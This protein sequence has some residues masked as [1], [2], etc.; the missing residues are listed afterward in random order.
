M[1]TPP[2]CDII[3]T[4]QQNFGIQS[5]EFLNEYKCLFNISVA[6]LILK[7]TKIFYFN[8]LIY[9]EGYPEQGRPFQEDV[10]I[11]SS[12]NKVDIC[13][14]DWND[15]LWVSHI[16]LHKLFG[17]NSDRKRKIKIYFYFLRYLKH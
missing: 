10:I 1:S 14:K 16:N 17:A 5:V 12:V 4:F 8:Y 11:E 9:I 15:L 13:Q 2:H 3:I 7:S 6:P